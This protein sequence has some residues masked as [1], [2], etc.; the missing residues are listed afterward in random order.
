MRLEKFF[1]TKYGKNDMPLQM[2]DYTFLSSLDLNSKTK[3]RKNPK[4]NYPICIGG[5]RVCPP[6]DC[7]GF[8]AMKMFWQP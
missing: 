6:D 4:I 1:K 7:G 2:T 5:E 8:L 3:Y